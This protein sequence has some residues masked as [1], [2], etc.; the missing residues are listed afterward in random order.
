MEYIQD[1]NLYS[2]V[3]FALKMCVS[4]QHAF[5]YK[6]NIAANY[7]HVSRSD[8]LR[9]VQK[10]LWERARNDAKKNGDSWYTIFNHEASDLLNTGPGNDYVFI[11]PKCGRH[12]ACNVHEDR[13]IDKIFVSQC[14]CG[15]T[16]EYQR[17]IVR[18][19]YFNHITHKEA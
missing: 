8:V 12:F 6:I 19:D 7:Y 10:E 17:K 18:K 9:I 5:D 11:C 14:Q 1:K 13:K 3:M 16:D 2:A 4:L 15:F